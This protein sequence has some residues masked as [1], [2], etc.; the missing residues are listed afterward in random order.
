MTDALPRFFLVSPL[1]DDTRAF[2]PLLEEA[3]GAADIACL[4]VRC[5]TADEGTIKRVFKE[6]AAV[7][8]PKGVACLLPDASRLAARV[9]ADGV[10][11]DAQKPDAAGRLAD[12]IASAAGKRIVGVGGLVGRD[13]AMTAGESDVDYLLFGDEGS[14][15]ET[16]VEAVAWWAEIFNVPCVGY[17]GSLD[18]APA[19]AGA[20]AEF[21]ALGDAV[22]LDPRGPATALSEVRHALAGIVTAAD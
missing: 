10:H 7:A 22:W 16:T 11:L 12:A 17:A 2:L 4:L 6:V 21:I 14:D 8:Q 1:L 13:A 15:A 5:G 19:I 9:D 3:L 20:G 18:A